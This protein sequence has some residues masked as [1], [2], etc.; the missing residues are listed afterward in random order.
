[1]PAGFQYPSPA[2]ALWVPLRLD[3]ANRGQCWYASYMQLVA[4]LRP[5]TT[6]AGARAEWQGL[7]PRL[8]AAYGAP[9]PKNTF[10]ETTLIP[11]Q[12]AVV[13][14]AGGP[15]WLLLGAVGL[16]LLIACS[17]VANLLLARA[18]A[19][20][21]EMALRTAFGAERLRIVRQLLAESLLLSGLG[22]G[23][24]VALAW[25]G[26]PLLKRVLPADL[27][28]LAEI[29][30]DGRVLAVAAALSLL[31]G[32][33][34]GLAPAWQRARPGGG[35]GRVPGTLVAIEVALSVM[36]VIAAGLA[37]RSLS[38]LAR[39]NP[40]F[41]PHGV[42]TAR[43]TP[44]PALCASPGRCL[45]F[46]DQLLWRVRVWPGVAVA[47]V[48]NSLPL[49]PGGEIFSFRVEAHPLPAGTR[50][51]L[52]WGEI[53]TPGYLRTFDIPLLRGRDFT[54]ADAAPGAPG[55]VLVSQSTAARLW[56]GQAAVGER[57]QADGYR[58][59]RTVVGVVADVHVDSLQRETAPWLSGV[60]YSPYGEQ[61]IRADNSTTPPAAMTL[62]LRSRSGH[63]PAAATLRRLVATLQP[64]VAVSEVEP[65]QT[66]VDGALAAP[67]SSSTLFALFGGLALGLG[68]VGLYGVLAYF[69][70]GR[71]REIGVRMALG[72]SRARV[73]GEVVGR[74]ARLALAGIAAGLGGALLL[75]R[76]MAS[77][78]YGVSPFDPATFALVAGIE[79][80]VALLASAVPARRALRVDAATALRCK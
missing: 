25:Q 24:G 31:T 50:H 41:D 49:Q 11:L 56:P 29:A 46:Y 16:L 42:L 18:A 59:W 7:R 40:G 43:I 23:L 72:A 78:L 55:V 44:S 33:L 22:G 60:V 47:A 15:L 9:M 12:Q 51:P 8:L 19:R 68:A 63:Q 30:L 71:T 27:P 80:A 64:E 20:G 1:M 36:L 5:G 58:G 66:V 77:L 57:L 73:L 10:A 21:P 2:M 26:L 13:G 69:V 67:R 48:V 54:A 17:N 70:A 14:D 35:R 39:V 37:V 53:V 4:R 62:A 76:L 6:L 28:R 34:F 75:T 45:Q 74:G 79:L 32:V 38:N 65:L 61:A 52:A 3:P